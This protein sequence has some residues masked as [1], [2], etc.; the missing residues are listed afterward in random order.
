MAENIG[1]EIHET[2]NERLAWDEHMGPEIQETNHVKCLHAEMLVS[3][4][5][6]LFLFGNSGVPETSSKGFYWCIV[7]LIHHF[8]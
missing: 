8:Y 7:Y 4:F 6:F 5:L 1:P 2:K 3:G